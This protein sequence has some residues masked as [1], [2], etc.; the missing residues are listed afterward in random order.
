MDARN[1]VLYLSGLPMKT[2]TALGVAIAS[3]T[4]ASAA[5]AEPIVYFVDLISEKS[6]GLCDK[7][8]GYWTIDVSSGTLTLYRGRSLPSSPVLTVPVPPDGQIRKEF[9]SP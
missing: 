8:G 5:G 6:L 9:K 2:V 4:V 7:G 3:C 1:L